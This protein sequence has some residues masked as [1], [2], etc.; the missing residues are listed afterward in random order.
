[1]KKL[2]FLLIIII[3]ACDILETRE[4]ELPNSSG[5]DFIT[6]NTPDIL[7]QNLKDSFKDKVAENY[8][9]CFVDSSFLKKTFVFEPNSEAVNLFPA[10]RDW[11][12]SNEK[13]YSINVSGKVNRESPILLIL[14]NDNKTLFGDS[15]IYIYDY[16]ISLTSN[17][18]SL[19][20]FY[21]GSLQFK[22]SRD[23]RAQWVIDSW[24]DL[25]TMETPTWSELKG[26]NY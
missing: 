16:S 4:P 8:M 21:Q 18:A 22:I 15:A 23:Q 13:Q 20:D 24:I 14:N 9:K 11:D 26:R 6:A 17:D 12:L 25:K 5:F 19:P 1:M 10:L 2:F 3:A 7:F